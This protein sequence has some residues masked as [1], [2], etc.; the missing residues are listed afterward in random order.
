[1][2]RVAFAIHSP[3]CVDVLTSPCKGDRAGECTNLFRD[4]LVEIT[5]RYLPRSMSMFYSQCP[6]PEILASLIADVSDGVADMYG[7]PG[8]LELVRGAV[9]CTL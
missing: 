5:D 3:E 7:P 6:G 4:A 2:A 8:I 9:R 1:M